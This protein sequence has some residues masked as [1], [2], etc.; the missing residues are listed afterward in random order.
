[1]TMRLPRQ[2]SYRFGIISDTHGYLPEEALTVFRHV[3]MILHAGDIGA[4]TILT[5]LETIAPVMA[6]RGNM[7]SDA[8]AEH[9]GDQETV[10]AGDQLIHLIHDAG[11]LHM[12]TLPGVCLTV[13]NGH[14]HR[15]R[16]ETKAGILF[17]NPGSAGAPRYGEP[18]SVALL[19]VSNAHASAD[20]IRLGR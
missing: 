11:R 3:D 13:I 19:R 4:E 17:V 18:A 20:L 14:T 10:Q 9:L 7:D 1:M 6:V 8:W 2:S 15:P 5:S 16:V 12:N